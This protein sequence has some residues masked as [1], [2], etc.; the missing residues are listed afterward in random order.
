MFRGVLAAAAAFVACAPAAAATVTLDFEPG[1]YDLLFAGSDNLHQ[2]T[3]HGI[4]FELFGSIENGVLNVDG[5]VAFRSGPYTATSVDLRGPATVSVR[6]NGD[7]V[8]SL[9]LGSAF[10]TYGPYINSDS[11]IFTTDPSESFAV[12]DLVITTNAVPEPATWAMMVAGFGL[13]GAAARRRSLE[14]R[15]VV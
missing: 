13:A 14:R 9:A 1:S 10:A 12:D 11:L 6:I 2:Y 15:A 7:I 5:G 8:D 4:F 3:S